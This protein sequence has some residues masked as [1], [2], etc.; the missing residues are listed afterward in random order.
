MTDN[1]QHPGDI[2]SWFVAAVT[3]SLIIWSPAVG[4]LVFAPDLPFLLPVGWVVLAIVGNWALYSHGRTLGTR[5][6]GFRATK[7]KTEGD[8][9]WKWGLLIA[10]ATTFWLPLLVLLV[11]IEFAPTDM[12][13]ALS[14]ARNYLVIGNR[15]HQRRWLQ[16]A[17][18]SW[19]RW[20]R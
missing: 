5:T 20:T 4:S 9:G 17:D 6:A 19:E 13:G 1:E 11:L 12:G 16:A 2:P 3:D 8:P 18:D 7:Y 15:T 10:L 14:S